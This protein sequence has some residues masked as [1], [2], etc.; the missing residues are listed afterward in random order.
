MEE[1]F[2]CAGRAVDSKQ[3]STLVGNALDMDI[4]AST[5]ASGEIAHADH[6]VRFI[7]WIFTQK[8]CS[9]GLLSS[10]G[11]VEDSLD[12]A[13]RGSFWSSIQVG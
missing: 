9:A 1:K 5:P 10:L 8:I 3:D 13:I 2:F 12:N 6:G 11:V 7:S 4:R